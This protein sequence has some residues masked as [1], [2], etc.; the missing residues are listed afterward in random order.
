M[1]ELQSTATLDEKTVQKV[2]RGETTKPRRRRKPNPDKHIPDFIEHIK[3]HGDVWA[4]AQKIV[5][6][7]RNYYTHIE[8]R[9][10]REVIVR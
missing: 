7:K 8:I 4:A 3:V 9:S 2:A 6:D 5:S 1:T 10:D